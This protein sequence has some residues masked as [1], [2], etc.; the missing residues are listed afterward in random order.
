[1]IFLQYLCTVKMKAAC[2]PEGLPK[3]PIPVEER[4]LQTQWVWRTVC[5]QIHGV[6]MDLTQLC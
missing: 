3:E 5:L 2:V 4:V 6:M 1:M